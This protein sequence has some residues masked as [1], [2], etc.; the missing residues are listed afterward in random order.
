MFLERRAT[1]FSL[2]SVKVMKFLGGGPRK[3]AGEGV[4]QP[5]GR[6]SPRLPGARRRWLAQKVVQQRRADQ[7]AV[8]SSFQG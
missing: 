7:A 5:G 4:P 1:N 8:N 3:E 6:I 2:G